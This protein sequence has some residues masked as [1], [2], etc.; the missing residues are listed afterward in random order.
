MNIAK[1]KL[2][3]D[4]MF[5][6]VNEV[7]QQLFLAERSDYQFVIDWSSSCYSEHGREK[8]PWNYYFEDCF[9][10]I[11]QPVGGL[12][13]LPSGRAVACTKD[14]IITPRQEDGNC[15]P[16]LLP[17][18]R[19][20]PHRF[21]EKYIV[22]KPGL[23]KRISELLD[24]QFST[25]TIGLHIRGPGRTDGGVPELNSRF[26]L[27]HGVPLEQYFTIVDEYI[28]KHPQARIFAC[29][30]SA[31]ILNE[32]IQRYGS[33]VFS[34]SSIRSKFGEM[35]VSGQRENEGLIFPKYKLGEDIIIEAMMLSQAD[36]FVH[37]NSNVVN[38]ILC[39]NPNLSH[40][41]IF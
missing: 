16:L 39:K 9:P 36:H 24:Q 20:L 6:N 40:K 29:S 7:I 22:L 32:V 21:I 34:H 5:S 4:G 25:F 33:K 2:R 10:G 37:G 35:H 17:E 38:F 30:D 19:N 11:T 3:P 13:K 18:D 14:N 28:S 15:A 31:V 1:L 27:R 41:Y 12:Q 8:D 26:P 23:R